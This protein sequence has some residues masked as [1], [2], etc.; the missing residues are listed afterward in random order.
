MYHYVRDYSLYPFKNIK[1]LSISEFENQIKY[2]KKNFNIISPNEVHELVRSNKSF[3]SKDCWLTFDDGLKDHYVHV[4]S[5]LEQFSIK[6]SFFPPVLTTKSIDILDVHKVHHILSECN[7][8][9]L[10]IK[11]IEKK[12]KEISNSNSKSFNQI[13]NGIEVEIIDRWDQKDIMLIKKLLLRDLNKSIRNK[14]CDF[15]FSSF[16]LKKHEISAKSLYMNQKE[17]LQLFTH[18]HEIGL[19]G[20]DHI[21]MSYLSKTE[22]KND[23]LKNLKFWN[24]LGVLKKNWSMCYPYG[25]YNQDTI[26]ILASLNCNIGLTAKVGCNDKKNYKRYELERW[27]TNDFKKGAG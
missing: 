7:D 24:N 25:D 15:L 11:L 23:I 18:G 19:H 14:I 10:I 20:Y 13:I 22:Q 6:A 2:F 9:K 4:F 26:D 16:V 12:Y 1:G 8:P 5:I 21:R 17:I 3:G 27:D